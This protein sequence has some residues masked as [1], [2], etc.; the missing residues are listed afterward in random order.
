M[1]SL[2]VDRAADRATINRR[3]QVDNPPQGGG[4]RDLSIFHFNFDLSNF[5]QL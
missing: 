3:A 5:S 4:M 2:I 1:L